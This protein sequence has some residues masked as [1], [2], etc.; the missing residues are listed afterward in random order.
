MR[1]REVEGEIGASP[2]DLYLSPHC[3]DICFS[4]GAMAHRR[5]AGTLL[6]ILPISGYV[7][8]RRGVPRPPA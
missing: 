5:R 6:T 3:D 7:P 8:Q 2:L 1:Q 4:L